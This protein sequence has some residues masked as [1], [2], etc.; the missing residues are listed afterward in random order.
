MAGRVVQ[1]LGKEVDAHP[2]KYFLAGWVPPLLAFL[3]LGEK[4]YP[5]E[6]L[7]PLG[8]GFTALRILLCRWVDVDLGA[9]LLPI[10]ASTLLPTHPLRS[11]VLALKVFHRFMSGWFSRQM[12]AVSNKN[13][14]KL[15]QAVGDPFQFPDLPRQFGQP[16]SADDYEPMMTVAVLIEFASSD[17]WRDHL[18]FSNFTSCEEFVST[19]EGRRAALRNMLDTATYVW[20]AFLCTPA[21]ITMAIRRLEELQ[22][23]NT[24]EVVILWAWT[25]G[26]VNSMDHD[27]WESIGAATVR[28][29][30]T[31]GIR[32][33]T[34]LKQHII[35]AS[36]GVGV[37]HL[38]FLLQT[39]GYGGSPCRVKIVRR[40][41]TVTEEVKVKYLIDLRVSQVCQ[42]RR[43]YHLFGYDPTTWEEAVAVEEV[44]E[45]DEVDVPSEGP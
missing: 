14:D 8:S 2:P 7:P 37:D 26:V 42:L 15:L 3:S 16:G 33:L 31:H 23:L 21:K 19:K 39:A 22:C 36:K 29:S 12:K 9:T 5:T 18:R 45:V 17:L 43:L 1:L 24:A 41:V 11:R 44:D 34:T 30:Q 20:S 32:H 27:G 40:P 6:P 10:L 13:L 28:F 4:L 25:A 38:E 35:D